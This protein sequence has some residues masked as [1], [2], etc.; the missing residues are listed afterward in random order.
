MKRIFLLTSLL[1]IG[2]LMPLASVFAQDSQELLDLNSASDEALLAV[3]GI[4]EKILDEIHEYRPFASMEHFRAELGKYLDEESLDQ[5]AQ[6]VTVIPSDAIASDESMPC[7]DMADGEAMDDQE[8]LDLNS[9]SDEELLAVPGIGEKILDE[10]HEYRPF[11]SMDHFKT[12]LGKYLDE[13]DIEAL[14]AY[15]TV[16]VPCMEDMTADDMGAADKV[17][18]NSASEEELLTIPGVGPKIADEIMEY[19]PFSSMDHFKTELGKYL[20]E[21][22]LEALE[23]YIIIG[24]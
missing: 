8:K 17:D 9:A 14:E 20:D 12:E 6:Y 11:S 10:I 15:L 4:G 13:A 16:N 5:L 3:P 2:F 18:V 21:A 1:F 22:D 7:D 19:R 24:Q 23:A